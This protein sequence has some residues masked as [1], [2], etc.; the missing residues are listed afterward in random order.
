MN[1]RNAKLEDFEEVHNIFQEVHDLHLKNTNNI[2]RRK[3]PITKEEFEEMLKDNLFL[4]AEEDKILG[5]MNCKINSKEGRLSRP[6]K[7]LEIDSIGVLEECRSKGIGTKLVNKAKELASKN[8]C[9]KI[10]LNVWSFNKKAHDF[11][12]ANNFVDQRTIMEFN[13]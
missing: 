3:D 5:F 10:V 6:R 13:L 11:Y 12:I 7:E 4:V 9:N 8:E 2:F 1:I